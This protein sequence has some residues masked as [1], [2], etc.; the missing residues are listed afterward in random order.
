[1]LGR[2][3]CILAPV[4]AVSLEALVPDDHFYRHLQRTLDLSFVRELVQDT[5]APGGRPSVDPE[6]FFK[7]HLEW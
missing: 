5:Y 2:K 3:E 7:V 1:M 6:V 4:V